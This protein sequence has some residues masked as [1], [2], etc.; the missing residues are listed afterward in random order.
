MRRLLPLL[1]CIGLIFSLC[2]CGGEKAHPEKE[3]VSAEKE[4]NL[5]IGDT[6]DF[7]A[8]GYTLENLDGTA[9]YAVGDVITATAEGT[10]QVLVS[11]AATL[12]LYRVTVTVYGDAGALGGRFTV[13]RGMFQGKKIIA[14]GDSITDGCLL[15]PNTSNGL[16]YED[17]Y[18][19]QLCRYLGAASDPSDL[20]N[21]NFACGG[22]TLT[23]GKNGGYGISGVERLSRTEAFTDGGRV[24]NPYPNILD[25]DLCI[26]FYGTNDLTANVPAESNGTDGLNDMPERMQDAITVRGGMYYMIHTLHKMNPDMK[27][28]VL[29]PLYRRADGNQLGYSEDRTD[30]VNLSTGATLQQYRRVIAE[31]CREN[32]AGFVDWYPLFH[33]ENFGR[34]GVST[35]SYDGL[36]PN[37]AGHQLMFDWLLAQL[38]QSNF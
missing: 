31:V 16:N 24:R 23:Y 10:D 21:C 26:L 20:E 22:T 11:D 5:C 3:P 28:L 19:A 13:D 30:V 27:I 17:T 33:Y 36:H 9:L 38:E 2:A 14:F 1:L 18:F 32:G 25:A 6:Y 15:D 12:Q 7:G 29:P 4:L 34:N 35:Y 8:M 37:V